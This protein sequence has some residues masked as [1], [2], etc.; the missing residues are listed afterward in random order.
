MKAGVS[1]VCDHIDIQLELLG[2]SKS[3]DDT[4]S[5]SSTEQKKKVHPK[6]NEIVKQYDT[7]LT[8]ENKDEYVGLTTKLILRWKMEH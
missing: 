1:I 8:T 5:P 2:K 7:L 3:K 4:L 6:L